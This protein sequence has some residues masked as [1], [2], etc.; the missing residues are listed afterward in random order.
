MRKTDSLQVAIHAAKGYEIGWRKL[1]NPWIGRQSWVFPFTQ[2][3]MPKSKY[4]RGKQNCFV[5]LCSPF[6]TINVHIV[7]VIPNRWPCHSVRASPPW[8]TC[9]PRRG[10]SSAGTNVGPIWQ[11]CWMCRQQCHCS[12]GWTWHPEIHGEREAEWTWKMLV[13]V[14]HGTHGLCGDK[15]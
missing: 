12:D 4:R 7:Y 15:G 2:P 11:S 5:L 9:S 1:G 3:T 8:T 14:D 10:C 6:T 13:K